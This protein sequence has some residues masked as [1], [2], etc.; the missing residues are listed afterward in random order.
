MT[1]SQ[2]RWAARDSQGPRGSQAAPGDASS[3]P[4]TSGEVRKSSGLLRGTWHCILWPCSLHPSAS[5]RVGREI[6]TTKPSWPVLGGTETSLSWS[7][8]QPRCLGTVLWGSLNPSMML[9]QKGLLSSESLNKTTAYHCTSGNSRWGMAAGA[10]DPP[11]GLNVLVP[12]CKKT[13]VTP[14]EKI[15]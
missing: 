11:P 4:R 5:L 12:H 3:T 8:L 15:P 13:H 9:G 10:K 6:L 14:V 7:A 1:P 2:E